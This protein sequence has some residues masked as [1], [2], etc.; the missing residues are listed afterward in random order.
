[1]SLTNAAD[2]AVAGKWLLTPIRAAAD[3]KPQIQRRDDTLITGFRQFSLLQ[4]IN[5]YW[6]I[7]IKL[8]N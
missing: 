7:M 4:L 1:M 5:I 3:F 8:I 2:R 6:Q